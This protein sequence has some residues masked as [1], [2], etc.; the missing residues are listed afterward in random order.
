MTEQEITL[1]AVLAMIALELWTIIF[2]LIGYYV[3]KRKE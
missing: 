3:G 1:R 2:Y